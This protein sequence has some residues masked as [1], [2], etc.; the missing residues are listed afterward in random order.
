MSWLVAL[1]LTATVEANPVACWYGNLKV[2]KPGSMIL[3][4]GEDT[5]RMDAICD[6]NESL[7][8]YR[9]GGKITSVVCRVRG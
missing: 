4:V 3:L 9:A 6:P 7:Q 8:I 5:A 2:C 1:A